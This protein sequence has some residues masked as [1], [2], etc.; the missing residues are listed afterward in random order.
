MSV[1]VHYLQLPLSSSPPP[2][3]SPARRL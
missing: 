1:H 3:I 2:G